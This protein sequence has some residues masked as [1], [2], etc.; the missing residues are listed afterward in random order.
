MRKFCMTRALVWL[1]VQSRGPWIQP[2]PAFAR[3]LHVWQDVE[4]ELWQDEDK[5]VPKAHYQAYLEDLAVHLK[6]PKPTR[7]EALPA[8]T[9]LM[10]IC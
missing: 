7:N 4:Y 10:E 8:E 1:F 5:T 9:D 2:N 6:E 3:Q